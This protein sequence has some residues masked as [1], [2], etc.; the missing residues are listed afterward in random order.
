RLL[1][2]VPGPDHGRH[3]AL[4]GDG[5]GKFAGRRRVEQVHGSVKIAF[6]A[7]VRPDEHVDRPQIQMKIADRAI[8]VDGEIGDS[9]A[10]NSRRR[11]ILRVYLTGTPDT[12]RK[13]RIGYHE[14]KRWR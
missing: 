5:A 7:A 12:K 10:A 14:V 4:L 9:H 2:G 1:L 11:T 13:Q 3:S 6:A 8:A